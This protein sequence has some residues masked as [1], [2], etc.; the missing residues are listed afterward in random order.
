MLSVSLLVIE[1]PP[2]FIRVFIKF[3]T[4]FRF[5]PICYIILKLI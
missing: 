1:Y 5:Y 2:A 4:F 3:S